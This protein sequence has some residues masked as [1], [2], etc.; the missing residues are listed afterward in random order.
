M[1]ANWCSSTSALRFPH[2]RVVLA[3]SGPSLKDV[4]AEMWDAIFEHESIGVAAVNTAPLAMPRN[5]QAWFTCDAPNRFPRKLWV[6]SIPW[7]F[8][9]RHWEAAVKQ[10]QPKGV[11]FYDVHQKFRPDSY[12]DSD[13]PTWGTQQ[14]TDPMRHGVR[15]IMLVAIWIL[16]HMGV[17]EINLVGCD[18]Q[19]SRN[20]EYATPVQ[21]AAQHVQNNTVFGRLNETWFPRLLPHFAQHGLS[22][23][24]CT[25]DGY[26]NAFQ[27]RHLSEMLA[28]E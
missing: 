15:S 16:Y 20:R 9:L 14:H 13:M 25:E 8:A 28:Q 26:L 22:V 18:F 21:F 17:R 10:Q 23:Y 3:C 1:E 4:P 27:R 2:K 5:P 24:N 6:R 11:T 12:L 19:M 7:K